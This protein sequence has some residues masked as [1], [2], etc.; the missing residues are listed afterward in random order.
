MLRTIH[1][2]ILSVMMVGLLFSERA[3]GQVKSPHQSH[4]QLNPVRPIHQSKVVK[5]VKPE[6]ETV[7]PIEEKAPDAKPESVALPLN[8]MVAT[9]PKRSEAKKVYWQKERRF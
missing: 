6:S 1:I 7:A 9:R 5:Q 2:Y 4:V 3:S 8:K